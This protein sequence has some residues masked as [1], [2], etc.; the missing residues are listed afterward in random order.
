MSCWNARRVISTSLTWPAQR[1]LTHTACS[2]NELDNVPEKLKIQNT[3]YISSCYLFKCTIVKRFSSMY[4]FPVKVLLGHICVYIGFFIKWHLIFASCNC[5]L[6]LQ[7]YM[8]A[9][10]KIILNVCN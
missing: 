9:L 10:G 5:I 2:L 4:Q 8:V 7:P 3:I 1:L 6:L